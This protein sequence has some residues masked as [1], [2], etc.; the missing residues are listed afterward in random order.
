[1]D[2]TDSKQKAEGLNAFLVNRARLAMLIS[3]FI[4]SKQYCWLQVCI[5]FVTQQCCPPVAKPVRQQ[6]PCITNCHCFCVERLHWK[7]TITGI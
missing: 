7:L 4:R 1:M 6:L 2:Q 5:S 3:R